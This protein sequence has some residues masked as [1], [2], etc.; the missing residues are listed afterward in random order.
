MRI[1]KRFIILI[2]VAWAIWFTVFGSGYNHGRSIAVA[3]YIGLFT[4]AFTIFDARKL[5]K[6]KGINMQT[7]ILLAL[8]QNI[9]SWFNLKK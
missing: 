3:F 2:I 8:K 7:A 5:K 9:K 4:I 1:L 6:R